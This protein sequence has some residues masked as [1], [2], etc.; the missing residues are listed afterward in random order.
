MADRVASGRALTHRPPPCAAALAV[1]ELNALDDEAL[2]VFLQPGEGG[3]DPA[4]LGIALHDHE[5]DRLAARVARALPAAAADAF[6]QA[7]AGSAFN[8]DMTRARRRVMGRLFWA[9]LYWNHPD[10][11]DELVSGE[12]IHPALLE[13]LD[14]G[15]CVVADLGCGSG[16]FALDAAPLAARV[17]AVDEVPALLRRLQAHLEERGIGNVEVRRGA[18][19]A[20]PLEDACVD[21]AVACS[22]LTSRAPCGGEAALQEAIRVVRPGGLVAVIWPDEPLW[23][24][25]RGFTYVAAPGPMAVHFASLDAARRLCRRFYSA[26]AERW[27][28]EHACCDVPYE[29]LGSNPPRDACLL[30]LADAP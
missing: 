21:V 1:E 15:G 20:L 29:V 17:I 12:T 4:Q 27:V 16:R 7:R 19:D 25:D 14:L 5:S 26:D 8:R 23:F 13:R 9:L 3:V 11:Y 18:F 22:S 24:I 30:R 28:V 6:L 2:R 10:E